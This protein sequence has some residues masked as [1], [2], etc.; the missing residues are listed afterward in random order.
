LERDIKGS[1]PNVTRLFIEVQS[2]LDHEASE[3][4]MQN[5]SHE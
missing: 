1:F 5:G 4:A 3:R 2:K